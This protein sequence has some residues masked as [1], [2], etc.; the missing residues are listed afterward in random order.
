MS[1]EIHQFITNKTQVVTVLDYTWGLLQL[2]ILDILSV[3]KIWFL[4]LFIKYIGFKLIFCITLFFVNTQC[5]R[6]KLSGGTFTDMIKF[7]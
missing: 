2:W 6:M 4:H 7:T 1:M 3:L 5:E